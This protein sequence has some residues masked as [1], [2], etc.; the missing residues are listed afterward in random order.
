MAK[1]ELT[2]DELVDTHKPK[3]V[4]YKYVFTDDALLNDLLAMH[5][6]M[7]TLDT[8][9]NDDLVNAALEAESATCASESACSAIVASNRESATRT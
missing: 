1:K 6:D 4:K 8:I 9:C 7:T 5:Y 2:P 3:H